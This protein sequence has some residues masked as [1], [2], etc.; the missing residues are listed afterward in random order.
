MRFRPWS[1]D[2]IEGAGNV[3]RRAKTVAGIAYAVLLSYE[4][5]PETIAKRKRLG[6]GGGK[7]AVREYI[8]ELASQR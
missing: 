7:C 2:W 6:R 5:I 8:E 4:Q 3:V 1:L